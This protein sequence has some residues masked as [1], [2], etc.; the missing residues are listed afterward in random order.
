MTDARHK[1]QLTAILEIMGII[2]V[3][4]FDIAKAT[5]KDKWAIIMLTPR[6]Q[7]CWP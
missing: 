7:T 3:P 6:I 4:N 1:D 5:K 2:E